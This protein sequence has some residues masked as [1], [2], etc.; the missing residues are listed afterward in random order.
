MLD[1][2]PLLP[3]EVLAL[4][5]Q[6]PQKPTPITLEG[7]YVILRPLDIARDA[8]T[9][10]AISNGSPITRA[11]KHI[12]AYD[13]EAL[14]W[15]WMASGAFAEQSAFNAYLQALLDGTD[16]L[17]FTVFERDSNQP[18]GIA[19][20]M[21]NFPQHLSIELGNIWY[22]PIAQ[23][24]NANL[25][26]TYLMLRHAFDLGYRRLEWKCD[27]RNERSKRSALRMGFVFE[28]V[29]EAHFIIKNRNRDTA[30]FRILAGEWQTVK[31]QLEALLA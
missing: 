2:A 28:G 11:D 31:A 27:N 25:E 23:R 18:V 5:A 12:E 15:R 17:P 30:W 6:L 4:R 10:F 29:Q 1:A 9:L 8:S 22:S 26:A 14:I 19:T 13:P 7:R 21:R 3:D 24:T 20:Y 16:N